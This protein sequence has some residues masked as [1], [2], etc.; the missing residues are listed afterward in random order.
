MGYANVHTGAMLVG[1]SLSLWQS[2]LLEATL[3]FLAHKK[4]LE[5][6]GPGKFN[7]CNNE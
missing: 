1:K 2:A 7:A 4:L 3:A 5:I 6:A